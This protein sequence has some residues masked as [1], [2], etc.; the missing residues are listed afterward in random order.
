[1]GRF[2]PALY[3]GLF[4]G[5]LSALPGVQVGNCCCCLWVVC[6]GI[7]TTYLLQGRQETPVETSETM[8]QGLVAGVAG[9]LIAGVVSVL[10]QPIVGPWQQ[11][12]AMQ[13]LEWAQTFMPPEGRQQFETAMQAQQQQSM[14]GT[15]QMEVVRSLIFVPVSAAFSTAGAALGLAFFRKKTPTQA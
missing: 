12:M 8:L 1:M 15:V 5:V 14:G 13:A 9:G 4:T 11:R 10:L 2:Q 3:G 7:L 6:G